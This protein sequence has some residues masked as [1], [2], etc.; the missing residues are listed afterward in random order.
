MKRFN[1]LFLILIVAMCISCISISVGFSAMSTTLSING[2]AVVEPVGM[3]RFLS[4]EQES[5]VDAT[6]YSSEYD[7]DTISV[8]LD[9]N[10]P[11]GYATYKV[12][13]TNLGTIDMELAK[14]EDVIFTND[15]MD[16]EIEGLEL[17]KVIKAKESL[18][19]TITFKYNVETVEEKR[20][21]AKI[22]FKF[23]NHEDILVND[24]L[25]YMAEGECVFSGKGNN[26][27]GDCS[28]GKNLDY[29]NTDITPFSEE[30]Y[31][32]NFV[33]KFTIK[34]VDLS[35]FEAGKRDKISSNFFK[36]SLQYLI[37]YMKVMIKMLENIQGYYSE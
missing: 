11:D 13:V 30:D 8:L 7:I 4:I 14:I 32:K 19:F 26:V 28:K 5:M 27:I 6:E 37:Y 12:N 34:D 35:R 9:I 23:E 22:K 1:N 29:I 17:G 3:I 33:L 2:T 16:Y 31:L 10:S 25:K 24:S 20:L 21:N 15:E 36:I 18:F